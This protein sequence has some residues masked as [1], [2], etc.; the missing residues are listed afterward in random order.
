MMRIST[1]FVVLW[2]GAATA[3]EPPIRVALYV[4]KGTAESKEL[5]KKVIE[6]MPEAKLET[7]TAEDIRE[8]KLKGFNTVVFPGGTGGGQGKHLEEKGREE[9]R[10]FVKQGGN[11]L[12]ICAG[13]YLATNDYEWSLNILNAK[14]IDRKHWARGHGPV[15][16]AFSEKG[17][18]LLKPKDKQSEI[19]YWQGPLLAPGDSKDLPAF[20]SLAKYETEIAENGAPMGVMKGTTAVAASTFGQGRVLCFSPHPEKTEST[21]GLLTSA[22]KWLNDRPAK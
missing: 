12:G 11:Y 10:N 5:V 15:Q 13:A 4:D 2:M 20:E 8:G 6:S 17:T 9:V 22:V 1:M 3:A 19:G 16:I 21:Y 18:E 7:V 14:V